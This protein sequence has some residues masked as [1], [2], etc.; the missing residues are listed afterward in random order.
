M[1]ID[2]GMIFLRDTLLKQAKPFILAVLLLGCQWSLVW[3]DSF[4]SGMG[5]YRTGKYDIAIPF[6]QKSI[7]ENPQDAN[8]V[9]YLGLSQARAQK[10]QDARD[11][12]EQVLQ[13]VPSNSDLATRARANIS[14]ITRT[15]ITTQG[16][17]K[18][19]QDAVSQAS[20]REDNYLTSIIS[21]GK[22]VHWDPARMPLKVYISDGSKVQGWQPAMKNIVFQAMSTWQNASYNKIRFVTTGNP[23]KA[24]II[25]NWKVLSIPQ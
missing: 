6:F 20:R 8:R 22:V 24:D 21:F 12:F 7:Q 18:T 23:S 10:Y 13:M 1:V 4:S 2:S 9:F 15:Q 25:V 19:A 14:F 5:A 16:T 3:A 17:N 11:S